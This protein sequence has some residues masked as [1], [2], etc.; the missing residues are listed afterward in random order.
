MPKLNSLVSDFSLIMDRVKWLENSINLFDV[1]FVKL[2]SEIL[3]SIVYDK[4]MRV[5]HKFL[6]SVWNWDTR[7][8]KGI[9]PGNYKISKV[10]GN[11]QGKHITRY[12]SSHI[13]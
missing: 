7:K 9:S 8:P 2:C 12:R 11:D 4:K 10:S 1:H 5:A 13:S 3:N 6:G